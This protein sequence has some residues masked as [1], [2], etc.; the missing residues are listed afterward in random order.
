MGLLLVALTGCGYWDIIDLSP[1]QNPDKGHKGP[2]GQPDPCHDQDA[3]VDGGTDGGSELSCEAGEVVHWL[4]GWESPSWVW[5]G[6]EE[7]APECPQG[8]TNLAYEG[9]ADLVAPSVC[10]ACTCDPPSGSCALPSK[11]T[12]TTMACNI[13]GGSSTSFDAPPSWD[14]SCDGSV[15]VPGGAARSLTIDPIVM[16]ESGCAAGPPVAAKIVSLRWDTFVRACDGG[17]TTGQMDRSVCLADAPIAP[18]FKACIFSGSEK[19]CPVELADNVFTEKHVFYHGVQDD[20]QCS[21]CSC[22]S[23]TGSVCKAQISIY[24]GMDLACGPSPLVP[25]PI[26][27]ADVTC[28]DIT[29]PGQA[30]GSKSAGPTTYLPGTCPPEGGVASGSAIPTIPMTVCCRP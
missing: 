22:G 2:N 25:I 29:L 11:L 8:A 17:M 13:S 14:G 30:L 26:T 10:E 7:Q 15:Q 4:H 5:I 24:D 27:S 28:L 20:R 23:P 6:P 12:A 3:D 1:C 9:R 19:E 18:E 21:A 16:T